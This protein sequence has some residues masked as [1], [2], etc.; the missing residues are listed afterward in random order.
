MD[1]V[2]LSAR[3]TI[4]MAFRTLP[5][6]L[7]TF[8]GFLAAGLGN[9]G[10]FVLFIGQSVLIP[11]VTA[12]VHLFV[13][14]VAGTNDN[15]FFI[16]TS[17]KGVLVPGSVYSAPRMN[18]APSYWMIHVHF[19]LAY[20]FSNA[21]AVN[22]L[23]EDSTIDPILLSNRKS[24]SKMI[25]ICTIFIAMALSALKYQTNTE[26]VYGIGISLGLGSI[27]GYAWYKFAASCGARAADVFGIVQQVIPSSAKDDKPMTCVYAPKP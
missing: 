14:K 13:A 20:L 4:L 11:I 24:K 27:L 22:A 25:M 26:T 21:A 9:L 16:N 3:A 10:L 12:F 18:V 8:I 17:E 23:P 1:G 7:I 15:R 6:I 19:L 2:I 5:L